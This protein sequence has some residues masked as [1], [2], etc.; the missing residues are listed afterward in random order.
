MAT[1]TKEDER[2]FSLECIEVYHSLLALWNIKSK[3]YSNRMKKN[4]Q[5]E[6]LLCKY[7]ERFPVADNNQS[8]KKF[9]SL[10][11]NFR[12]ELKRI[13]DSEKKWYWS[14]RR[15]RVSGDLYVC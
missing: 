13:R 9:N 5:Y 6:H 1:K 14:R 10:P 4:E 15:S 2:K 3:D 12:K 8:I 7:R 11:T